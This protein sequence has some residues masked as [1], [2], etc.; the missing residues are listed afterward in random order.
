MLTRSS[1]LIHGVLFEDW[2][3]RER[4]L[5]VRSNSDAMT[6]MTISLIFF[7]WGKDEIKR[8]KNIDKE[9]CVITVMSSCFR[10]QGHSQTVRCNCPLRQDVVSMCAQISSRSH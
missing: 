7:C 10:P 8:E 9:A 5:R 1:S 4:D 2:G 3:W 6:L